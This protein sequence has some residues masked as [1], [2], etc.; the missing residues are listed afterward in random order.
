MIKPQ[1]TFVIHKRDCNANNN[2]NLLGFFC[3]VEVGAPKVFLIMVSL[4]L[5]L[6]T[7]FPLAISGLL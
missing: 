6:S 3:T 4:F 7:N 5:C 1:T 2:L